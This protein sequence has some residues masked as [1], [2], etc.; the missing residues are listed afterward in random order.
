MGRKAKGWPEI[1]LELPWD[2]QSSESL[3]HKDP[4]AKREIPPL[5]PKPQVEESPPQK[6]W[7]K[8]WI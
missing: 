1:V 8:N 3:P 6:P 2:P 4:E 5:P 7:W